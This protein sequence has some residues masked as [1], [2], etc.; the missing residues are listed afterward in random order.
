MKIQRIKS[1][2]QNRFLQS[3]FNYSFVDSFRSKE[4]KSPRSTGRVQPFHFKWNPLSSF[5]STREMYLNH[6]SFNFTWNI[7]THF[8]WK[9]SDMV[10]WSLR[11]RQGY[12]DINTHNYI[13]KFHNIKH[14]LAVVVRIKQSVDFV[15]CVQCACVEYRYIYPPHICIEC[16]R[17]WNRIVYLINLLT[18]G[19]N[20]RIPHTHICTR[21]R[22]DSR[23]HGIQI[24]L[25]KIE[26]LWPKT[27]KDFHFSFVLFI[28][29]H[30]FFSSHFSAHLHHLSVGHTDTSQARVYVNFTIQTLRT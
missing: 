7:Y 26:Y 11:C 17:W 23:V 20:G 3:P 15:S 28:L 29:G 2:W 14:A 18:C 8:Q 4:W 5:D 12:D 1:L 27:I 10:L 13:L 30:I 24:K 16:T 25:N 9:C 22:L 6:S 19:F 21:A